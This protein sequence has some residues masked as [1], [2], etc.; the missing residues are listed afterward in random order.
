M[1]QEAVSDTTAVTAGPVAA[2]R[3]RSFWRRWV[4]APLLVILGLAFLAFWLQRERIAE[5]LIASELEARGIAATYE[6]ERIGGRRQVL[7]NI[8]V[9]DPRRPS[10]TIERAE[11]IV[12]YR[13]GWPT[14][15]RLRLTRPRIFGTWIDGELS[16]GALDPLLFTGE[17]G[18]FEFP[19]FVIHI[20]D[21]RGL[22]ETDYGPV[23][24][25]LAG[26]GHLRGGFRGELAATAPELTLGECELAGTTLFGAVGIDAERPTFKGP[27]RLASLDCGDGA[28]ALARTTLAAEARFDRD[29]TGLEGKLSGDMRAARFAE[30]AVNA[31]RFDSQISFRGGELTAGYEFA[32]EGL[33]HPQAQVAS[34]SAEGTVR[35]GDGFDWLRLQADFSGA[36][37]RP[38]AGLDETIG[39]AAEA[40]DGT[41]LGAILR[42]LRGGLLREA[43]GSTL[44]GQAS[45]RK[46]GGV[47]SLVIPQAAVTGGSGQRVLSLSRF[48]YGDSGGGLPRLAGNFATGGRDLPRVEGRIERR[49]TL[50]FTARLAMATYEAEGG[51]LAI[52]SL[53]LVSEGDRLGFSGRALLSGNLPGGHAEDLLLPLSGNWSGASGLALWRQCAQIRFDSLRFANV[54]LQ[55]NRLTLCPPPGRAMVRYG[56]SGLQIAAGAPS[57]DVAGLLGETPIAVRSGPVGFAYPGALSARELQVTLGPSDTATS[58][59]IANL[60]AQIGKNISGRFA[61]TD[62]RLYAVPL[63]LLGAEGNWDYTAGRLSIADG[64]FRL[65]DRQEAARF[66]PLAARG[67]TLVLQDNLITA[68][69]DLREP[70]GD[71]LVTRLDLRHDLATGR[72]HA[73]LAVPGVEFG[74]GYQPTD[75]TRLA[76]GVVANVSGTVTGNGRIDWNESGVTSTGSFS[77]ESLDFAAAFGP[78]RGAS[79]TLVFTDLLGLTTARDQRIAV[80]SV[81]PGI[82]VFDG[83]IGIEIRNGEVLQVTGG[84][85]PFMGGTLTLRP[86]TLNLGM[87]EVRAYILEIVGLE[88][89]QFVER[90]E[91]ENISATGVF[92][93]TM[94]LI[95]D[96][97]GN[98]RIEGGRLVSRPP[99]G[100][101]A[102]VGALTYEDLSPMANI[103]FDA[104]RSLDYTRMT[105]AMDGPLTGEIVTRVRF[106]GVSQGEGATSNFITRRIAKLPFRFVVNIRAPFYQLITSIKSMYDPAAVRDPRDLGLIDELGNAIRRQT[107]EAEQEPPGTPPVP[108][109]DEPA[110]QRRESEELP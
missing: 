71:R 92:D 35:A 96:Q 8:V 110:I 40:A 44:S 29:L 103:A 100:N 79:G 42:K 77:S 65:V 17:E 45:F 11:V 47:V 105:V 70:A 78:V 66:E 26:E 74:P 76:L 34:I 101:V 104:L 67:A 81:N 107:T 41:L 90:M 93:G 3:R 39:Q 13:F 98:G 69:A 19:N 85:W 16:F 68:Q 7:R 38:G 46:T 25:R 51:R 20:R 109:P 55:R 27:L 14:I 95:F 102:Y 58:F 21:G 36:G 94:P 61:G 30:A 64:S 54:T 28:V 91:L 62:V 12:R 53:A 24:L 108:I 49:G 9:G 60:T 4:L 48:Q 6:I 52:P 84:T 33:A 2:E 106:D 87:S 31:L 18:P 82:E 22:L 88:A 75:L 73:D 83:E 89:S 23:G 50:G 57:L 80:A 97:D 5:N 43:T 59:A 10:L 32:G 37:V 15:G 86:V 56:A 99:G 63:D 1:V 72:G